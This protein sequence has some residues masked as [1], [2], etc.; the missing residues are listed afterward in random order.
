MPARRNAVKT[1]LNAKMLKLL[2]VMIFTLK[3]YQNRMCLG[4]FK[5]LFNNSPL[6]ACNR[7][8]YDT[9]AFLEHI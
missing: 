3:L 1:G 9:P 8:S 5:H 4:S 7:F 6:S 2:I